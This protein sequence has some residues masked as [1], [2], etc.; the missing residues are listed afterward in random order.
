MTEERVGFLNDETPNEG[1]FEGE[2]VSD[3][4]R[5]NGRAS[6]GSRQS[7]YPQPASDMQP[8][9]SRH[10]VSLEAGVN[11][12]IKTALM[13][14][15]P[16]GRTAAVINALGF[17]TCKTIRLGEW[18]FRSWRASIGFRQEVGQIFAMTVGSPTG[19]R[20]GSLRYKT[21]SRWIGCNEIGGCTRPPPNCY[22][23]QASAESG[24]TTLMQ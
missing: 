18:G 3:P 16:F 4:S 21:D 2:W 13:H 6:T 11:S 9:P 8:L 1:G 14:G 23:R 22:G 19:Q 15:S 24:M 7:D 12:S 17:F 10:S 20:R 5:L